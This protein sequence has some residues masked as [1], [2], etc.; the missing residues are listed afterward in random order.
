MDSLPELTPKNCV[1][2][3]PGYCLL[4]LLPTTGGPAL[5]SSP[6]CLGVPHQARLET[7]LSEVHALR[8]PGPDLL[9]S[10]DAQR[11]CKNNLSEDKGSLGVPTPVENPPSL[12]SQ[13]RRE[14]AP[15][16]SIG[17]GVPAC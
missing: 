9:A 16:Q 14:A 6:F 17:R 10:M 1:V 8:Y 15:Y 11:I 4:L 2:V 5:P 7:P 12:R 3:T 13:D